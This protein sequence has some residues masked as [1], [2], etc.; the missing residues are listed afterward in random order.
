VRV[1]SDR[2][3]SEHDGAVRAGAQSL[4]L[5]D[6]M[7]RALVPAVPAVAAGLSVV[8]AA[9]R[10]DGDS[11]ISSHREREVPRL[12]VSGHANGEIATALFLAQSTFAP[13]SSA[14]K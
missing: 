9:L 8:S 5:E 12:V 3:S 14:G 7:E 6:Q 1:S 2:G 10:R 4:V 11:V 13:S